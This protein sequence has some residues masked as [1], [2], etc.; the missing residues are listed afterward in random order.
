MTI[1]QKQL[2]L[3]AGVGLAA[4]GIVTLFLI[5]QGLTPN[6][7]TGSGFLGENDQRFELEEI[8]ASPKL[9]MHIHAHLAVVQDGEQLEVPKEIGI[10]SDLWKDRSLD[11]FGPSS[12]LLSPMHTHDTSGTIHIE[13]TVERGYTLGEFL[14]IWGLEP[15]RIVRV[16]D[17]AGVQVQDYWNHV[18]VKNEEL[19]L[20]IRSSF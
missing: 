15:A 14:S 7:S 4:S 12:G 13:S 16:T 6:D 19:V 17:S 9:V 1:S 20:E 11:R 3:F 8:H 10:S 5:Y 2:F 18:L